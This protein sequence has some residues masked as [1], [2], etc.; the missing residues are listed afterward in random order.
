MTSRR[1]FLTLVGAG[2][3]AT[4]LGCAPETRRGT[5]PAGTAT[6]DR[7]LVDTAGGL[8]VLRGGVA[9]ALGPAATTADGQTI[10]TV[11]AVGADTELRILSARTGE[12]TRSVQLKGRW[13]P[14]TGGSFGDVVAL[15]PPGTVSDAAY[16]PAGRSGTSIMVVAGEKV[17]RLDLPGNYT[18]DA[19]AIDATGLFVLDWVPSTA[20]EHYRVREAH[21]VGGAVTALYGRDKVPIPPEQ[22]EQMRG[23]RRN[24]VLGAHNDVLYTL[25][26]HQPSSSTGAADEKEGWDAAFIHT[27]HL[28]QR[29]AH[30]IDLPAPFG[31][32]PNAS[33]AIAIDTGRLTVY[34]VDAAAGK[35]AVVGTESLDVQRV[36]DIPKGTGPAYAA[37]AA[38]TLFVATGTQVVAVAARD[39]SSRM[40]GSLPAEALG[41][42]SSMDGQRVY[43]GLPDSV[44]WYDARSF[45]KLGRVPVQ[46]LTGLRRAV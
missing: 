14:S 35:L 32:D 41:L 29:W 17:Q 12:V 36:L 16:P 23:V 19:F 21:V 43:A 18:P 1:N 33:H 45:T 10:F 6:P 31:L 2:A 4:L 44:F 37:F 46:G 28:E 7:L 24:A 3:A 30:C 20:P 39:M 26:T 11:R 8:V 5:D 9:D 15:V 22:E 38:D 27:L 42:M 40:V 13:T 25:Y 34:V